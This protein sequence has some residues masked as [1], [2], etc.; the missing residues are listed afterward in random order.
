M[1]TDH[2]WL[3][4]DLYHIHFEK[5]SSAKLS[6]LSDS[7]LQTLAEPVTWQVLCLAAV[8]LGEDDAG[9]AFKGYGKQSVVNSSLSNTLYG[10]YT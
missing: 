4:V 3:E 7:V 8:F 1:Y 5:S 10:L 6:G 9:F 2:C